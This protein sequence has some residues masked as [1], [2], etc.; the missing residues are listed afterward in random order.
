MIA[1]RSTN[2]VQKIESRCRER[3]GNCSEQSEKSYVTE[4]HR[5]VWCYTNRKYE[6]MK[7]YVCWNDELK[8]AVDKKNCI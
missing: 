3:C 2:A 1:G 6:K 7:Q 8:E 4:Y 5:D